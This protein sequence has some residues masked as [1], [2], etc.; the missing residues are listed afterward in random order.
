M[1]RHG[2]NY[3]DINFFFFFFDNYI[4]FELTENKRKINKQETIKKKIK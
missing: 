1:R 3:F 2:I 4:N